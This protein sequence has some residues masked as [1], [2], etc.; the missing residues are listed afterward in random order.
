MLLLRVKIHDCCGY[1]TN[2][3]AETESLVVVI[4]H[5]QLMLQPV[6]S[7]VSRDVCSSAFLLH[8]KKNSDTLIV[9]ILLYVI[10]MKKQSRFTHWC[11]GTKN[12]I[13]GRFTKVP[14]NVQKMIFLSC[15]HL[16]CNVIQCTT[17]VL[18]DGV[19]Q[20][21]FRFDGFYVFIRVY[22]FLLPSWESGSHLS[23]LHNVALL[24]IRHYFFTIVYVIKAT[25][26]VPRSC[27]CG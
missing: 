22:V 14:N 25:A 26:D 18:A 4:L 16:V 12:K 24:I 10:K 21:T 5:P 7:H 3:S 8:K 6:F 23:W 15:L 13:T 27:E 19:N 9:L 17:R 2:E 20:F 1:M 11:I